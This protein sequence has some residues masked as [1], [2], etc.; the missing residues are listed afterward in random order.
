[1]PINQQKSALA[2]ADRYTRE[3]LDAIRTGKGTAEGLLMNALG[4]LNFAGNSQQK[5][6]DACEAVISAANR[7]TIVAGK[8]KLTEGNVLI[9]T[10]KDAVAHASGPGID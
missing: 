7:E 4:A 6:I 1:M 5:L 3:A 2:R 8:H 9:Q 10:V